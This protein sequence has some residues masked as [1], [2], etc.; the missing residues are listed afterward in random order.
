MADA[1]SNRSTH[2]R[3]CDG[4]GKEYEPTLRVDGA[5]RKTKHS[6]C[7]ALCINK[8]NY[9]S[10]KEKKCVMTCSHC[11]SAM[12]GVSRKYCNERCKGAARRDKEAQARPL[13]ACVVCGVQYVKRSNAAKT[14]S[15]ACSV[16]SKTIERNKYNEKY[17]REV[18]GRRPMAEIQAEARDKE[19]CI[20]LWEKN[21]AQAFDYWMRSLATNE[22]VARW[23]AAAGKPWRNKRLTDAEQYRLQ[24]RLDLEFQIK[25]R[26]RRQ[27]NKAQKRDGIADVMRGAIN[28]G[29]T[30]RKVERELG[31][32]IADLMRHIEKQFTKRMTWGKFRAGEIH[33]DHI[34]P[35]ASFDLA[36][37]DEW[38]RCWCLSNL[39]PMWASENIA[40]GAKVMTLC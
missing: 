3:V 28:C 9:R 40:K 38:R 29:G 15:K 12:S 8:I 4:C 25:E 31:Y 14:C 16:A 36:D 7:S 5:L 37:D 17:R 24:Y 2:T 26:M 23:W 39:R 20:E 6:A 27:V 32:S 1:D 21:A 11:G 10:I 30:S 18:E 35:Q 33:I 13:S 19:A 22:Q 34:L